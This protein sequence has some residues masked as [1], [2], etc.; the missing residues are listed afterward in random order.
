MKIMPVNANYASQKNKAS[1]NIA[2][3]MRVEF[4]IDS[5]AKALDGIEDP[6]AKVEILKT[7]K[8]TAESLN[9]NIDERVRDAMDRLHAPKDLQPRDIEGYD[10]MV[11][12]SDF[13]N[14]VADIDNTNRGHATALSMDPDTIERAINAAFNGT[15]SSIL[16]KSALFQ[17]RMAEVRKA[18]ETEYKALLEAMRLGQTAQ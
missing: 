1:D 4:N 8:R 5:V 11:I 10:Q 6:I 7:I 16:E 13:S 9:A 12:K 15:V 3:G 2:F 17:R 18:A 14:S